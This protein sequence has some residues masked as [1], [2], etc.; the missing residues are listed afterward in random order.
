MTLLTLAQAPGLVRYFEEES[1][2]TKP[3]RIV[4]KKCGAE[5]EHK[6]SECTVQI[7]C[8]LSWVHIT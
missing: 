6:T 8:L 7:V 1:E 2:E 5:N 3:T 4:C